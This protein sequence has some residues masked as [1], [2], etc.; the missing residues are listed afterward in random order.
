MASVFTAAGAV[1]AIGTTAANQSTDT[2]TTIANV[3]DIPEFGRV[4]NE[5]KV[6]PLGTRGVLKIK[7]SFDEGTLAVK[8][9]RDISDPGQAAALIARDTDA[10]FNFKLTLNDSLPA[11]SATVTITIASPGVITWTAHGLPANTPVKFSTTGAL[12]TGLTAGT[13][14]FIVGDATLLANS[15]TVSATAGGTAITTTGTQSGVHTGTTVPAPSSVTW[16]AKVLSFT[17]AVGTI[18][19]PIGATM[20]LALKGGSITEQVHLP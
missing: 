19:N 6:Q 3:T 12:P 9:A 17:E 18:D 8:M 20:S 11:I 7:G 15:F 16:K 5:I 2:Y 10:D 13:T 1:L 4:Y 14:Y